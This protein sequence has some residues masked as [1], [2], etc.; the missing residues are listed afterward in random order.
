MYFRLRLI[1]SVLLISL[2]SALQAQSLKLT[3]KVLNEKNEPLAGVS[4]KI[5]SG[6]GTTTDI[7]GRFSLSLASGKKYEIQFTAVGYAPKATND[8]EVISGQANE[9][10]ITLEVKA[11]TGD[12]VVVSTKASS[13]RRETI[14][15]AIA[16]QKNT[17]TVAQIVSAETIR[18]SPDKNTSEVL[19]RVTG[20]SI[21]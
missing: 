16:F 18:R 6:G 12:N 7:E 5:T 11:Q 3:G 1:L 8:A 9:L 20:T 13:A 2:V 19:K 21:Q 15:S 4:V 10:N 17:N 14:N